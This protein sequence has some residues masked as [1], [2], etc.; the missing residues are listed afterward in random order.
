MT[1]ESVE[2]TGDPESSTSLQIW[3][4]HRS[5]FQKGSLGL[6]DDGRLIPQSK[7]LPLEDQQLLFCTG[8]TFGSGVSANLTMGHVALG[9]T[10]ILPIPLLFPPK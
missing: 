4:R 3:H 2:P 7:L 1:R 5:D 9:S 6:S 10:P 8:A